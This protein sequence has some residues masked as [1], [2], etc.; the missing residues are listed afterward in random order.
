MTTEE[1][2]EKQTQTMVKFELAKKIRA[3]LNKARDE[4]SGTS[5]EFDEIETEV[6]DLVFGEA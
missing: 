4:Y 2:Q 3:M 6:Q 1:I 5:E